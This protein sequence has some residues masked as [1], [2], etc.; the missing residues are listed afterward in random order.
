MNI[1]WTG[2]GLKWGGG[3]GGGDSLF[4]FFVGQYLGAWNSLGRGEGGHVLWYSQH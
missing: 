4:C 3:G 2:L 1:I